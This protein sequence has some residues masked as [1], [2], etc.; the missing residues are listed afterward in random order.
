MKRN[1][2]IK[3]K[4]MIKLL[5]DVD[6]RNVDCGMKI[7]DRDLFRGVGK[8]LKGESTIQ[9]EKSSSNQSS[10]LVD[11]QRIEHD[12]ASHCNSEIEASVIVAAERT[13][14]ESSIQD[15][16]YKTESRAMSSSHQSSAVS[17]T[18]PTSS[19]YSSRDQFSD[20][21]KNKKRGKFK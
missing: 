4:V 2:S 21:F 3:Q 17:N 14:T 7:I 8:N 11:S 19:E 5:D 13:H 15:S 9:E 10:S 12:V 1:T 18:N 6:T 16:S 20:N